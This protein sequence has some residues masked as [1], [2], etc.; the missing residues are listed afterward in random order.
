MDQ[1]RNRTRDDT[2]VM[3]KYYRHRHRDNFDIK[4][5]ILNYLYVNGPSTIT[6][7]VYRI[8]INSNVM[9]DIIKDLLAAGLI[10][11]SAPA[12]CTTLSIK[13]KARLNGNVSR[14]FFITAQGEKCMRLM[15]KRIAFLSS[16]LVVKR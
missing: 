1:R 6:H 13:A 2:L 12:D 9:K 14:V 16:S 3:I 8:E 10:D 4:R 5:E 11:V 15:N 7:I